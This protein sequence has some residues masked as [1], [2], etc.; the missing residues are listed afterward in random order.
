[1]PAY[2][3]YRGLFSTAPK[4]MLQ[5]CAPVSGPF[6]IITVPSVL[7]IKKSKNV[8]CDKLVLKI[9]LDSN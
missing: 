3:V 1:M 8:I 6:E 2:R 7:E 9:V 5:V 4:S